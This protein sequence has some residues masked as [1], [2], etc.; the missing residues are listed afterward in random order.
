MPTIAETFPGL[1]MDHLRVL[2]ELEVTQR[3]AVAALLGGLQPDIDMA[4]SQGIANCQAMR[5]QYAL[6]A[7][8]QVES[9]ERW[10][11]F[12]PGRGL[13]FCVLVDRVPMRVQPDVPEIR[14]ALPEERKALADLEA[15]VSMFSGFPGVSGV[16]RL[17][18]AQQ[19]K[20]PVDT[21]GLYFLDDA[22]GAVFDHVPLYDAKR[23]GFVGT[24]PFAVP[25]Q[26]ASIA[27][28]FTVGTGANDAKKQ[29]GHR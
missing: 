29:D 27:G 3:N 13:A 5:G 2:V 22:T 7:Q 8:R 17:E 28:R 1:R 14:D 6:L 12:F 26:T 25:A 24:V 10:L 23:G 16:L 4:L 21:I 19:Q 11:Q 9:S 15:Q 18:V 20:R